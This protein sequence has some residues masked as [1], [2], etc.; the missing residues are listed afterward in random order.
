MSAMS[1]GWE[2]AGP[3]FWLL[4]SFAQF[5][6]KGGRIRIKWKPNYFEVSFSAGK[7]ESPK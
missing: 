2:V 5:L 4:V 6:L 1:T 3:I 7:Q